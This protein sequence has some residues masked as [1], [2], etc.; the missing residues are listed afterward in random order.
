MIVAAMSSRVHRVAVPPCSDGWLVA[1]ETT[2]TCVEGGNAGRS[3]R[4]WC[5]L[6]TGQ[7]LFE[8]PVSPQGGS[9]PRAIQLG[10]DLQIRRP[11]RLRGPQDN[12]CPEGQRLR[13][14]RSTRDFFQRF[15]LFIGQRNFGRE[16]EGHGEPPCSGAMILKSNSPLLPQTAFLVQANHNC[17]STY[18]TNA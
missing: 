16:R 5:V 1:S 6:Q 4:T 15:T 18:E 7:T 17:L 14:G 13:R 2:S 11:V 8:I 12:P 3:P 9:V 10:R